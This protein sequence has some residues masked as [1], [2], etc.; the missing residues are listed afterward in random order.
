MGGVTSCGHVRAVTAL[1][2]LD[3]IKSEIRNRVSLVD[4]VSQH[5]ALRQRGDRY[6]GLC[7]FHTEKTPSFTVHAGRGFFKCFGCGRAGDVFTFVMLTENVAFG[8]ALRLLA[9]RAGVTLRRG[10][11][12]A[13]SGPDRVDLVR[14]NEWACRVFREDLQRLPSAEH[15]RA[16]IR[17]RGIGADAEK[18]FELGFAHGQ[19]DDLIERARRAGISTSLLLA[20]DLLRESEDG[21]VYSSFRNRLM[22]PIRDTMNRVVGFGGRALGDDKAKYLN[23]RETLL[24]EKGKGFYGM[25]QA[26]QRMNEQGRAIVTEGYVDAIMCHQAGFTETV[27][28][29][30]TAL[31]EHQVDLLRRHVGHAVFLFDSDAAGEAAADRAV[32]VALPR[33]LTVKLAR[34]PDGKD[35]ADFFQHHSSDEF[36]AILNSAVDALEFKWQKLRDGLSR[37]DLRARHAAVSEFISL[38][39]RVSAAHALDAISRGLVVNQLAALL[40]MPPR[41]VHALLTKETGAGSKASTLQRPGH[42]EPRGPRTASEAIGIQVLQAVLIEPGLCGRAEQVLGA[43]TWSD[44]R[45]RTLV[46]MVLELY[47]TYGEFQFEEVLSRCETPELSRCAVDLVE[48]GGDTAW[49]EQSLSAALNRWEL[50]YRVEGWSSVREALP[51]MLAQSDEESREQA[52]RF[53]EGLRSSRHFAPRRLRQRPG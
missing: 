20:A 46:S 19:A 18:R 49:A 3:A 2:D 7:P 27:A 42:D 8:D 33:A 32:A 40:S 10:P 51:S 37:V 31:T 23:T 28:A 43:V 5:V 30:G 13:S 44:H 48:S 35:P 47:R 24:F 45:H 6:T 38:I 41:E 36:E 14:V 17:G 39:G 15:A 53:T 21:R 12:K 34:I 50:L 52:R 11:G 26:R 9:D 22:F 1:H 16:Y 4:V 25:F 29:L